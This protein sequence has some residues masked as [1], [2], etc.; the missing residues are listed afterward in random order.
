MSKKVQIKLRKHYKFAY[1]SVW[2]WNFVSDI[3]GRTPTESISEK[4]DEENI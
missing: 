3:M 4:G 1:S 2:V